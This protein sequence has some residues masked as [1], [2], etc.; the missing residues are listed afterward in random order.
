MSN[1]DPWSSARRVAG[2]GEGAMRSRTVVL[3]WLGAMLGGSVAVH[4]GGLAAHGAVAGPEVRVAVL[5]PLI[6][7]ALNA[8]GTIALSRSGQQ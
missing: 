8:T 1:C 4:G 7:I 6:A 2:R 3:W 5:V